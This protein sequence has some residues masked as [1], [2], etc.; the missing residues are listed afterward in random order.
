M[1]QSFLR[2]ISRRFMKDFGIAS[3]REFLMSI[4]ISSI[5]G[6]IIDQAGHFTPN[7]VSFEQS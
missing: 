2:M 3:R 7:V 5:S 1:E 6:G 4:R